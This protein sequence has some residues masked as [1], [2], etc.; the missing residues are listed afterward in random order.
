[1]FLI[2]GDIFKNDYILTNELITNYT[3][4]TPIEPSKII[5]VGANY[6]DHISELKLKNT[7]KPTLFYK[8]TTSLISTNSSII[9]PNNSNNVEYEAELAFIIKKD[10]KNIKSNHDEYILGYTCANDVTE[11]GNQRQD[12]QWTRAKSYDTFCPLG[13]CISTNI[14]PFNLIIQAKLNNV[15]VQNSN[16]SRM[17]FSIYEILEFISSIMTL[18]KGDVILTGTPSGIGKLKNKDKIEIF[19]EDIGVLSNDVILHHPLK[20]A[21]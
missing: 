6:T 3:I 5:A 12:Q 9:I 21:S 2:E 17:I 8:P 18:R 4:L 14:D 19:I 1:M 16:T 7:P 11:R 20:L 15:I 10:C 13:P